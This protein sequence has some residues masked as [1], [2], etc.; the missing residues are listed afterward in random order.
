M[1]GTYW[2]KWFFSSLIESRNWKLVHIKGN[3]ADKIELYD[4]SNDLIENNDLGALNHDVVNKLK[5]NLEIWEKNVREGVAV[6][7]K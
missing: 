5:E 7:S 6:L 3:L 4:L 2:I 1:R